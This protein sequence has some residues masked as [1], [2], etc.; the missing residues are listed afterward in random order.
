MPDRANKKPVFCCAYPK[1][2]RTWLRF[3][4]ANY[5]NQL[6]QFEA[7]IDYN[8]I[9]TLFPNGGPDPSRGMPAYRYMADDRIP[10]VAFFHS[11]YH[12]QYDNFDIIFLVRGIHD[13]LVSNY[14]QVS[15]RFGVFNGD[16]KE[17]I[18]DPEIGV[19]NL[20]QYL[21]GWS[22]NLAKINHQVVS[23][24][25]MHEDAKECAAGIIRF[26]GLSCDDAALSIA[27]EASTFGKMKKIE[28]QHGFPNPDLKHKAGDNNALRAREGKI[29][30]Y[31]EYLDTEDVQYIDDICDKN[32]S[33]TTIALLREAI[34]A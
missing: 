32:L 27:I 9:F 10:L 6:H 13:T 20:I 8:N 7:S 14:F 29:G 23:Y 24:E 21:N 1:S 31:G 28:I 11:G 5:F 3:V 34:P 17:Y 4:L 19:A 30:N 2:G 22:E 25:M 15:N 18:R 33:A 16:I 26:L 12:P